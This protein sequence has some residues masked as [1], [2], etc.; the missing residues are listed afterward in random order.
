MIVTAIHIVF[1]GIL[2]ILFGWLLYRNPNWI[3]PYGEMPPERK[4][5]VNID[6]LKRA[7][8]IALGICG[9]VFFVA[10]LLLLMEAVGPRALGIIIGVN[11][12][13][14]VVAVIV[15]MRRYNGF[16]RDENGEGY[17]H[18]GNLTKAAKVTVVIVMV[19]VAALAVFLTVIMNRK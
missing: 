7:L 14:F 1:T 10:A 6:G 5:L 2:L 18:F 4:A 9:G 13:A 16:A 12:L 17:Y 15:A 3:N 11:V 8:F 19:L